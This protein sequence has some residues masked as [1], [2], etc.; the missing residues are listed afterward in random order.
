M[1]VTSSLWAQSEDFVDNAA[2]TKIQERT[3]RLGL[4]V[5]K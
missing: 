2:D 5:V 4:P 3:I 1:I